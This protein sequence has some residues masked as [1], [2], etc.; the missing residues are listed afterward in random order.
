MKYTENDDGSFTPRGPTVE[1]VEEFANREDLA[2][3]AQR[4]EGA[5]CE[6]LDRI[7]DA[8]IALNNAGQ[9]K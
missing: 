2:Y 8:V 9:W 5:M 4:N 1:D 6:S 7:S 3:D